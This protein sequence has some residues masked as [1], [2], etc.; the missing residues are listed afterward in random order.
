MA[1]PDNSVEELIYRITVESEQAL[2][3]IGEFRSQ[4]DAMK[5]EM[6]K[7]AQETGESFNAIAASMRKSLKDDSETTIQGFKEQIKQAQES[8]RAFK[9]QSKQQ[10]GIKL[11]SIQDLKIQIQEAQALIR[12]FQKELSSRRNAQGNLLNPGELDALKTKINE[13]KVAIEGYR[14]AVLAAV[15]ELQQLKI[16]NQQA[17]AVKGAEQ[18]AVIDGLRQSIQGVTTDTKTLGAVAPTALKELNQEA[19]TAKEGFRLLGVEIKN[20]GD[21]AKVVF[22]GLF[23]GSI[24][25]IL[26]QIGQMVAD[27]TQKG[28][29]FNKAVFQLEVGVRTLRRA[30]IDLTFDEVLGNLTE[31]NAGLGNLFSKLELIKGA[32]AF[33]NLIRD[34]GLTKEQIIELQEASITLAVVNGRSMEDVQRTI[35][36][37]ISSGYTEGLQRLGVSI[38]RLT[39]AEKANSLG[40]KGGYTALTEQQRAMATQIIIVKKTAVYTNDLATAQDRLFGSIQKSNAIIEN[41]QAAVG[42]MFLPLKAAALEFAATFN[43]LGRKF[44]LMF[45]LGRSIAA[46][47][48]E[49][50]IAA[51]FAAA[52][53]VKVFPK[54]P[55]SDVQSS[56]EKVRNS[57]IRLIPQPVLSAIKEFITGAQKI[58]SG[59]DDVTD[60]IAEFINK[61]PALKKFLVETKE[62]LDAIFG[63]G[64]QELTFGAE[65]DL[66]ASQFSEE[67]DRLVGM[68]EEQFGDISK[69]EED[70]AENRTKLNEDLQKDLAKIEE[71]GADDRRKAVEDYARDVEK[72]ERDTV[73]RIQEVVSGLSQ[74]LTDIN[75][76]LKFDIDETNLKFD[77]DVAEVQRKFLEDIAKAQ[78]DYRQKELERERKYQ[79]ELLRL[80]EDFILDL[81]EALEKR[82]ARAVLKAIKKFN[83][84]KTRAER[85][86]EL[87]KL[88]GKEGLA[89]ELKE[90]QLRREARIRELKFELEQRLAE[91]RRNADFARA[92]AARNAAQDIADLRRKLLEEKAERDRAFEQERRDQ[93]VEEAIRRSR[94]W[95]EHVQEMVE[96]K[97]QNDAKLAEISRFLEAQ[98]KLLGLSVDEMTAVITAAFGSG[99]VAQ[100]LIQAYAEFVI[101]TLEALRNS[102]KGIPKLKDFKPGARP[103]PAPKPPSIPFAKGGAVIAKMPTTVTFGEVP[104]LAIFAPL[105]QLDKLPNLLGGMTGEGKGQGSLGI[106]ISLTPGLEA[107]IIEQSMDKIANIMFEVQRQ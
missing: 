18:K 93:I 84:D 14:A 54:N 67:Q 33:T 63:G 8:L 73:R 53:L 52:I 39:I 91:L 66:G 107:E 27:M 36:L 81:E 44:N 77:F 1:L 34:L 74:K 94:R 31:I 80:R 56:I 99:G 57:L 59:L 61:H 72:L 35:A 32:A 98:G 29:E 22:L 78:E 42:E 38:N 15:K 17:F 51:E 75:I 46:I 104:E 55:F 4:V 92:E 25:G 90:L 41:Q 26:H 11:I 95:I 76:K 106:R 3:N 19:K 12:G 28:L 85:A 96:L 47:F 10:E 105:N 60:S 43:T 48:A 40:F 79:E 68:L 7:T 100:T 103:G 6:K 64:K 89:N 9:E 58:K 5:A 49:I 37:A 65:V 30:G 82:D 71:D 88:G 87:A 69:L 86:N 21:I 70:L 16:A 24:L 23:G 102:I 62:N 13:Q 2:R 101:A 50:G 20:L 97:A 83:L 45:V